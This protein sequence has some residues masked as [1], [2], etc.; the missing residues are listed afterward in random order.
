MV[1]L[2]KI[3]YVYN[4]DKE[5]DEYYRD[6]CYGVF[7]FVNCNALKLTKKVNDRKY[8]YTNLN[9][10]RFSVIVNRD[11]TIENIYYYGTTT[12]FNKGL[13][14]NLEDIDDIVE[15]YSYKIESKRIEVDK[16]IKINAIRTNITNYTRTKTRE[17]LDNILYRYGSFRYANQGILYYADYNCK[18]HP[19]NLEDVKDE[20]LLSFFREI[21][22]IHNK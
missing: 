16:T 4:S 15:Y 8:I 13:Y 6:G 17:E 3:F 1:K 2:N 20:I 19:I 18:I 10:E 21:L 12:I 11:N 22:D 9:N 7:D 14:D 5:L